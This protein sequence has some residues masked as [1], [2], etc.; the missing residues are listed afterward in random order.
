MLYEEFGG[1][2]YKYRNWKFWRRGCDVDTVGKN[3]N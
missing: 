1:L 2:K 3:K